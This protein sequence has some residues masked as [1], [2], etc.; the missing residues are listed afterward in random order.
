MSSCSTEADMIKCVCIVESKPPSIVHF[1]LSDRVLPSTNV[2]KHGYATIGSLQTELGANEF[3]L[4]LAN[5][6]EGN[7]NLTLFVCVNSKV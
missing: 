2:E 7:A 3:V 1:M 5:N 6:T 4:C